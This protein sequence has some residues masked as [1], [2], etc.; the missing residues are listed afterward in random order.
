MS[1][2]WYPRSRDG[3]IHLVDTWLTVFQTKASAWNIPPANV[4]SLTNA[5]TNAKSMLAV[6]KSGERTAASV[7]EC[8]EVF[9]EMET[10]ARFIKKHFLLL[11]PLALADLPTLLLPLPDNTPTLVPPPAGQPVLTITY[12]GGPHVLIVHLVPLPGTKPPDS[13]GDYD[14]ALYRGVMPQGGAA[15][16]QAAG[17]KHCLMKEPLSGDE[18][19]HYRFTR[20]KKELV[21]FDASKSGMTTFFCARYE[22]QKGEYGIWGSV[23]SAI[24]P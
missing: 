11:S 22:N 20:R 23:V 17:M 12:S 15:L 24:I 19:L 10:E 18:L 6:V 3:Q 13:R 9:K 5:D 16:E 1:T 14:C 21:N 7:V 2:D 8:N 4:T